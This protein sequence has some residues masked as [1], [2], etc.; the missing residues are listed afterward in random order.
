MQTVVADRGRLDEEQVGAFLR[1]GYTHAQAL[2]VV[3]GVTL[4]TLTNYANH[5]IRPEI[6]AEFAPRRAA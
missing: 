2:E 5:L 4:K 3:L 6:N 1:A